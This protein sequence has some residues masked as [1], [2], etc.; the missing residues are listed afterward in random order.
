M[1]AEEMLCPENEW[2]TV[3]YEQIKQHNA[4]TVPV[5]AGH[6]QPFGTQ[7]NIGT[8]FA[9]CAVDFLLLRDNPAGIAGL[10]GISELK[11]WVDE[12]DMLYPCLVATKPRVSA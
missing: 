1:I 3:R 12:M 10:A 7:F 9:T 11:A 5:L 8:L 6:P 4:R 2:W